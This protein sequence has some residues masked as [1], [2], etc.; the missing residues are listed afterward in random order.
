MTT[1]ADITPTEKGGQ[2]L[3]VEA[4]DETSKSS[5]HLEYYRSKWEDLDRVHTIKIF[6]KA[7]L[8]C[9]AAAFSAATDGYQVTLAG[10]ISE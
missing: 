6:W 3:F 7:S 4:V 10:N 5:S 8:V 1:S 2:D 9:F